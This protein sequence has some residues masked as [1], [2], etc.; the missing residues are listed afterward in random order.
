MDVQPTREYL[1]ALF[2]KVPRYSIA[3][4]STL[5]TRN[6]EISSW[7][8]RVH[9]RFHKPD[10]IALIQVLCSLERRIRSGRCK[11]R[12]G[13]VLE[14]Q[15]EDVLAP[16]VHGQSERRL[17]FVSTYASKCSLHLQVSML[18]VYHP[19]PQRNSQINR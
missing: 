2:D 17:L 8:R 7:R 3:R 10:E 12:R 5:G 11:T 15:L 19:A 16:F 9:I 18:T 13:A 1:P 14:E 4:F 6:E